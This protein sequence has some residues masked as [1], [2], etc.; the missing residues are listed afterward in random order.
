[1][2]FAALPRCSL[3]FVDQLQT[4]KVDPFLTI[5]N[6]V[7]Y[8]NNPFPFP[9]VGNAIFHSRSRSQNLGM[10][11]CIPV[12]V[13]G[14]GLSESG[15][16]TGMACNVLLQLKVLTKAVHVQNHEKPNFYVATCYI[17]TIIKLIQDICSDRFIAIWLHCSAE[18]EERPVSKPER[19]HL[20][21]GQAIKMTA[22]I[23]SKFKSRWIESKQTLIW[24]FGLL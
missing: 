24:V 18:E 9:K 20:G 15:L 6:C 21:L 1:M 22:S 11:F 19:F 13:T 16:R 17:C 10:Q 5:Q 8:P 23:W 4:F 12:P 7:C 2:P 14:N 3:R